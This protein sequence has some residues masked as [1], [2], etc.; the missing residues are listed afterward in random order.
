MAAGI[1]LVAQHQQS[2]QVFLVKH[3]SRPFFEMPGGRRQ[4]VSDTGGERRETAYETA[5]REAFEETRGYLSP[6]HL[7]QIVD[8]TRSMGDRGFV[9]FFAR[10]DRFPI[11]AISEL[12]QLED[13]SAAAFREVADYAWV[14]VDTV[15]AGDGATVIDVDG[16]SIELRRELKARLLRARAAGWF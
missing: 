8:S 6:D 16:R 12:S 3:N 10:T 15:L 13:D 2:T 11:S 5:I 4:L 14:A 7:R 9:F 1:L